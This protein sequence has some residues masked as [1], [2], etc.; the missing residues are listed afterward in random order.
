MRHV[1]EMLNYFRNARAGHSLSVLIRVSLPVKALFRQS[2]KAAGAI[3]V[4]MSHRLFY[5]EKRPRIVKIYVCMYVNMCQLTS[6]I[7]VHYRM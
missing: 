1:L 6:P 3:M 2:I 5:S 4:I 7:S